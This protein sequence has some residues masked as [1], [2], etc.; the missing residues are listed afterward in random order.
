M[1]ETIETIQGLSASDKLRYKLEAEEDAK[2]IYKTEIYD[3]KQ[4]G[5]A[6]GLEKG[7][8]NGL[9][10]VARKMKCSGL[11]IS[12]IIEMTGLTEEEINN[13]N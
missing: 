8:L 5:E 4:E 7:K 12:F 11:D 1:K 3:A 6:F 13:I 2:R 9:K 10:D